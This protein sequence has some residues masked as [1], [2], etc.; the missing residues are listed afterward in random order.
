MH[1]NGS[2]VCDLW[3]SIGRIYQ[4]EMIYPTPVDRIVEFPVYYEI[5]IKHIL[6]YS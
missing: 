4:S 1:D 6:K 3:V 5:L 2:L